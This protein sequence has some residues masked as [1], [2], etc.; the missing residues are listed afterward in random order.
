V[1]L[2]NVISHDKKFICMEITIKWKIEKLSQPFKLFDTQRKMVE[3]I[4]DYLSDK[5]HF[6]AM[7]VLIKIES[8]DIDSQINKIQIDILEK[9]KEGFNLSAIDRKDI[10]I[11]N[12]EIKRYVILDNKYEGEDFPGATIRVE[13]GK[14]A[15]TYVKEKFGS[16]DRIKKTDEKEIWYYDDFEV[17]VDKSRGVEKFTYIVEYDGDGIV[18][19]DYLYK[20]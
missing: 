10:K 14:T 12:I 13:K 16:P 7:L 18:S 17:I 8:L 19:R 2:N 4:N 3:F 11:E 5:V 20:E 6:A 9:V 15:K 1:I